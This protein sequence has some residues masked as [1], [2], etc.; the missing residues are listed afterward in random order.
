MSAPESKDRLLELTSQIVSAQV[1][2]NPVQA[3]ELPSL[4]QEVYQTLSRV[5]VKDSNNDDKRTES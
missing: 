5:G 4:I 2:N 1:A 3:G